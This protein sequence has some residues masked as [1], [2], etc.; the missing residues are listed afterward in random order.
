MLLSQEKDKHWNEASIRIGL[1]DLLPIGWS[2]RPSPY[3]DLK[4]KLVQTSPLLP[5]FIPL[6]LTA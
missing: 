5:V 1:P 6:V 3:F 4:A 2:L